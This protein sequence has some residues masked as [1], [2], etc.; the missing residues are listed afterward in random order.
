MQMGWV[1][2]VSRRCR[3][4]VGWVWGVGWAGCGLGV[5]CG[6]VVVSVLSALLRRTR[7]A[8]YGEPPTP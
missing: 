6:Q 8:P 2:G 7:P 3:M 4:Q 5:R 1:W